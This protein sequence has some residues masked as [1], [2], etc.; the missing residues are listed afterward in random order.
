MRPLDLV[1]MLNVALVFTHQVDA[2]YWKEFS[3]VPRP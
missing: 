2:A 3:P 1:A